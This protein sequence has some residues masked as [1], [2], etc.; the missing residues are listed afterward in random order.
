MRLPRP[1][2][3]TDLLALGLV[4]VALPLVAAIVHGGMQLQRLAGESQDLVR[5]SVEATH[6]NE[7]LFENITAMERSASLYVV[8]NDARLAEAFRANHGRFME[9]LQALSRTVDD[10]TLAPTIARVG[11]AAGGILE[12][13]NAQDPARDSGM[14]R[15]RFDR[16]NSAASNLAT[17]TR[18]HIDAQ[19]MALEAKAAQTR[20]QQM[21][22]LALLAPATLIFAVFFVLHVM[23]PLRA[24]E[25]AIDELGRGTFSQPITVAGP[26][27]LEALGRQLEWL[28]TRLLE[29]AQEKNRFLRHMSHELKTPLANIREGTDLL[30]EGAVGDLPENQREVVSILQE[31]ALSLQRLIE[32]LLSFSAWQSRSVGLEISEFQL[33]TVI[34]SV[35]DAQRLAIVSHRLRLDLA[36]ADV[37][38]QADRGKL[39]L[40]FDNLLSNS[41]KFT[42]RGGTIHIHARCEGNAAVIDF[43]D[44]GPG[45]PPQDREKIFEAF[46]TGTALHSGPLKGTGIGL[47]V[48]LEFLQA[49]NGKVEIVDGRFQGAHF[50]LTLPLRQV[51]T[52]E[53][54]RAA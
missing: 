44:S 12:L 46:H 24:I 38:L 16:L 13:L 23:K 21:W 18:I 9:T 2:S 37:P 14:V 52:G 7:S 4:L 11:T 30:L 45:I 8:L 25:R 22:T 26:R 29:L 28:R 49:H 35:V 31:N 54:A 19:V 43:A 1:H 39:R 40:V 5:R 50:Q 51:L 33:R 41:L 17:A 34:K 53:Q 27:D 32:N 42:P 10:S 3:L 48:V 47:S 6:H 36:I 20:Q 15:E